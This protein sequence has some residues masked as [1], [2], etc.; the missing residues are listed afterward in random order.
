MNNYNNIFIATILILWFVLFT[1]NS[2]VLRFLFRCFYTIAYSPNSKATL[3]YESTK[4]E[5]TYTLYQDIIQKFSINSEFL[6]NSSWMLRPLA[7]TSYYSPLHIN[8]DKISLFFFYYNLFFVHP[9]FS[10]HKEYPWGWVYFQIWNTPT[11]SKSYIYISWKSNTGPEMFW[12]Y[13]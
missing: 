12:F 5:S 10:E 11:T 4:F 3:L 6:K 2:L 1:Y 9:L 7:G 13:L 8:R